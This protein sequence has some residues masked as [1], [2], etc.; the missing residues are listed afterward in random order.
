LTVTLGAIGKALAIYLDH[1]ATSPILADVRAVLTRL[2]AEP[3]ANPS[4]QHYAGRRARELIENARVELAHSVGTR[5]ENVRF[6][7][8]GSE[9]NMMALGGIIWG[10]K[11]PRVIVSAIE[12]P[13][14]L[15]TARILCQRSG[16]ALVVAPV[17]SSGSI[18]LEALKLELDADTALVSVMLANH[19]TGVV[20]PI[21][22]IVE[23]ASRHGTAV[24][25]DASQGLG[26][27]PIHFD[28][29]GVALMSFSGHK[30]GALQGV[31]ALLVKPGTALVATAGGGHQEA[32]LRAGTE[33]SV[34]IMSFGLAC[35]MQVP[36]LLNESERLRSLREHLWKKIAAEIPR[37]SRTAGPSSVSLPQT[38]NVVFENANGAALVEVLSQHNVAVSAGAACH[39]GLSEP[40]S[41]LLAMGLSPA[42]AL[43]SLRFSF[44]AETSLADIEAAFKVLKFAVEEIRAG[45]NVETAT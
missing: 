6:C 33:N 4:S 1:N 32:G 44:A 8:G 29:S 38:L 15:E 19:E 35:R 16:K 12:H 5:P 27:I 26:R 39:A 13:S 36:K 23:M 9:A 11:R 28:S 22:A 30:V 20:Q 37:T 25:V 40:S 41:V 2:L 43:C 17:T 14:V 10:S 7:S 3:I 24:H 18:D 45:S 31:G 34:G 42:Q 21:E